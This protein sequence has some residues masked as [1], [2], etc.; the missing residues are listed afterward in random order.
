[1]R[2][3]HHPAAPGGPPSPA[4]SGAG[5]EGGGGDAFFPAQSRRRRGEVD[6][7]AARQDG[8]GARQPL[9]RWGEGYAHAKRSPCP[10][11]RAPS[12]ACSPSGSRRGSTSPMRTRRSTGWRAGL[13]ALRPKP[14][15]PRRRRRSSPAR[16]PRRAA[17]TP[18]RSRRRRPRRPPASDLAA[19]EAAIAAFE[20]C[21]L[22]RQGARQAVFARG[23]AGRAGD[24]DRRGAGRGRGRARRAV[25]RPRRQAAGQDAGARPASTDRVF[26]TNTV[27]WRPPGNRTPIARRTGRLR[28]RSGAGDRA[29][30]AEALMLAG[31]ASAKHMLKTT[32][33][34]PLAAR[35]LVRV[36]S[37]RRR[38]GTAGAADPAPGL[39]AAPAAP[40]RRR[41]GR[42]C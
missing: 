5:Q 24:G 21:E 22:K 42:T 7:R 28:A 10:S 23:D 4:L 35:P 15:A 11:I 16:R 39:P 14:S 13:E 37:E 29:G 40:P 6:W 1:M 20:G 18:A 34:H 17:S 30:A 38:A 26:I 12:K 32:R 41:P 8:G 2:P 36:A 3:L 31:G 27:F 9:K 33:R 19:L 25:R